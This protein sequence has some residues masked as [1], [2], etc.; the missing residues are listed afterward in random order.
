MTISTPIAAISAQIAFSKIESKE[1][2]EKKEVNQQQ[3]QLLAY[4]LISEISAVN[5]RLDM[6]MLQLISSNAL[7]EK[8][9]IQLKV[10]HKNEV[11]GLVNAVKLKVAL[12]STEVQ[13][14][15]EELNVCM[16]TDFAKANTISEKDVALIKTC[17]AD[18]SKIF[19]KVIYQYPEY[20]DVRVNSLINNQ[21][22]NL[23]FPIT[24]D[25]QSIKSDLALTTFIEKAHQ[26]YETLKLENAPL[27]DKSQSLI[28]EKE[29]MVDFH[30]KYLDKFKKEKL[31]LPLKEVY[32][33]ISSLYKQVEWKKLFT[34]MPGIYASCIYN[35]ERRAL[36]IKRHQEILDLKANEIKEKTK[37]IISDLEATINPEIII[38]ELKS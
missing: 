17:S 23:V 8:E 11:D 28:N 7:L 16:I 31:N 22:Q 33:L 36:Y 18:I 3:S 35:P 5:T 30:Q 9:I 21:Q 2:N 12:V 13:A 4:Q 20:F 1:L 38:K 27:E 14:I 25:L 29:M 34:L 24:A 19:N 6:L 37:L 26:T 10:Q 15:V 32:D